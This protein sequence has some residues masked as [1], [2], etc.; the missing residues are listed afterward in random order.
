MSRGA[1]S[2]FGAGNLDEV[3]IFNSALTA[4]TIAEHYSGNVDSP[5]GGLHG[6]PQTRR[7]RPDGDLRRLG[8]ERSRR[9]DRQIRVGPRRQRHLRDRHRHHAD[10]HQHLHHG[11]QDERRAAGDRQRGQ[12]R[13]DHA[14]LTVEAPGSGHLREPRARHP[15]AARLLAHGRASRPRLRRQQG[16][17]PATTSGAPTLGVA[18]R[19]CR[20]HRHRGRASTA[21]TT[22]ATAASTSPARPASRSSSGSSGTAT[23]TTTAWRWSSPTNFNEATAASWSTRTRRATAASRSA[24]AAAASRNITLF[25]RPSA[26]VWHHYAFVLD[27]RRRRGSR[28]SPTSTAKRSPSAR[29]K[30]APARATSPTR[31]LNFMSRAGSALFGAGDLDEVAIYDRALTPGDDRRPLQRNGEPTTATEASFTATPSTAA[32]S[33]RSPS[34]PP[35]RAIPTAR[36]PSTNGTSTAT[37][38]TRPTP[39]RRRP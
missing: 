20:R 26:G 38:P 8:L 25:A 5:D 4:A 12:H 39:A 9:D 29:P 27:T 31:T 19:R 30:P 18:R 2:L 35:P 6:G 37:G 23:P 34:T 32:T 3:A 36:S 14:P 21:P 17:A 7:D 33:Q 10:R 28:S 24:S 16:H 15:R 22:A 11:G 13:D 1:S